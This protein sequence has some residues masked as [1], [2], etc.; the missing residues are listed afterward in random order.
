MTT[1][2]LLVA[3]RYEVQDPVGRGGM[4]VVHRGWDHR[5]DRPVAIKVFRAESGAREVLRR[6]SETQLLASLHHASLVTLFDVVASDDDMT[7]LVMELVEGPTLRQWLQR[8]TVPLEAAAAMAGSLAEGLHFIHER[9]IVHRDVK[10]ANVLLA[11]S[12]IPGRP[13]IAKLSDF[14]I[15]R[16]VDSTRVTS[17]GTFVGTAQYLSPEQARGEHVGPPSDV[18]SLGLTLLEAVT[19]V[20]AFPGGPI[21]SATARLARDPVVPGSLGYGW[22]S[23]LTAMTQRNPAAR[24]SALEVVLRAQALQRGD[25]DEAPTLTDA[26]IA[27]RRS[28]RAAEAPAPAVA[29]TGVATA[30]TRVAPAARA[31][32]PHA[33]GRPVDRTEVLP[34]AARFDDLLDEPFDEAAATSLLPSGR[35]PF[36]ADWAAPWLE[37][38]LRRLLA[39]PAVLLAGAALAA[40]L[41]A[42]VLLVA[43]MPG[44]APQS[45]GPLPTTGEPLQT[46]LQRLLESVSR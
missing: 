46:H 34:A 7:F 3:D 44:P 16:I 26:P 43:L 35:A 30:A 11:P 14:G 21:E 29:A 27:S 1:A 40:V 23:L 22:K 8:G 31:A 17:T 38:F 12:P 24:P 32:A 36:T 15:A 13:P 33:A 9:G 42:V 20:T 19:G 10:P 28:R 39:R 18:Y 4:A 25:V 41:L 6:R 5:L 2:A 37:A 45:A